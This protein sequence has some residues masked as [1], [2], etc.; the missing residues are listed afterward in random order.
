MI[1]IKNLCFSEY[2]EEN[3]Q[4]THKMEKIFTNRISEKGLISRI[5]KGLLTAQDQQNPFQ[6]LNWKMGKILEYAFIQRR[7]T[8]G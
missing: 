2:S 6:E 4:G 3:E 7:D 8:N 1:K 5:S